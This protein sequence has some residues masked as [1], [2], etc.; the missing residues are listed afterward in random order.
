MVVKTNKGYYEILKNVRE[1][2]TIERFES[3]YIEEMYDKYDFLVIDIADDKPRI[4]GFDKNPQSENYFHNIM[5]YIMESCN[6]LA[7]YA[8]VRRINEKEYNEHKNDSLNEEITKP[9]GV[10][11]PIEKENFDKDN[12]TFYHTS[13]DEKNIDLTKDNFSTVEL[14]P[15]PDDIKQEIIKERLNDSRSRNNKKKFN[16]KNQQSTGN[17]K[18]KVFTHKNSI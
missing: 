2:F 18:E 16:N 3:Y 12:L 10:V 7:P 15:L 5:D 13:P 9:F 4:K 17:K 14:Y 8:I 1:A 6:F 11:N